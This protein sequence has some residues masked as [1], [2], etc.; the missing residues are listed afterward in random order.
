MPAYG[1]RA[2]T[3]GWFAYD[4]QRDKWTDLKPKG[5]GRHTD[6]NATAVTYDSVNDIVV[7]VVFR[8]K[9][10]GMY[11]YD[12]RTNAW[13]NTEPKPL[14]AGACVRCVSAFYD[15]VHNAHYYYQASDSRE[16]ST[17]WLYR[18][19]REPKEEEE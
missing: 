18:Y 6:Q 4:V 7:V 1:Y 9:G 3:P 8:H 12:A 16:N 5:G 11:V 19:K 10:R 13:R 17:F 2:K 15:P 14:P